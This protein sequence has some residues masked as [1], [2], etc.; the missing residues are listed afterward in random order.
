MSTFN[1]LDLTI[2]KSL[3][4]H[5]KH[6]LDFAAENDPGIFTPETWNFAKLITS[7]IK[8]NKELPTLRVIT[9]KLGK[10]EKQIESVK[11]IWAALDKIS[12]NEHEYKH[13]LGKI[14][15]RFAEK[16]LASANALLSKLEPGSIDV[17]KTI[18]ELQ[19]TIQ[20]IKSLDHNRTYD[21]KSVKDY[22]PAFVDKFNARKNNPQ[23]DAGLMTKYS[24]LD[25]AT[26][27]LRPA[28]FLV[29]A[30]ETGF[31]KSLFLNNIAIQVWLQDNKIGEKPAAQMTGGKDIIYFSL[32]MPYEDC[33]NRL[34]SRLAGVPSRKI[35]NATLNKEE[36]AKVK[37][38]L[39]FIKDYPYDFK[40]VDIVDA[41]A[42]D[43]EAILIDTNEHF[44][45]IFI[46][47]LGIMRTN[48]K[49]EDQDWLK[50]GVISYEIRAIARKYKLP[51]FSAVQLNRKTKGKE[52]SETI[53][54]NRLARSATIA[55]HTTHIIQIENRAGEENCIDFVYHF[56]KNRKGPKGKGTLIKD[57][58]CATLLDKTN[59]P[60]VED[61]D[62]TYDS[63]FKDQDDISEEIENLS[64]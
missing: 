32:E 36:M 11:T 26:N 54:L 31:G 39:D 56:I 28:D 47:Y 29:I 45:A 17:K 44:D 51:I 63:F 33:F 30:G 62:R 6:A 37:V 3:I 12:V 21:S 59:D 46:D 34:L 27:G 41:S 61:K 20:N 64:L 5:K 58:A 14:K 8:I 43:L 10:N 25:F 57:L 35:E 38:C 13:D 2:L 7:Y 24:F 42:N 40:I 49:N 22:L 19:K 50:Q 4:T 18:T 53:G 9:E 52:A 48:E 60:S 23:I 1:T 15:Q 16:Q 55:T